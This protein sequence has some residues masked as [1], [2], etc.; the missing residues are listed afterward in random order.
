VFFNIKAVEKGCG[1][2]KSD[3]NLIQKY[4]EGNKK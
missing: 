3:L 1:V 4:K 2:K